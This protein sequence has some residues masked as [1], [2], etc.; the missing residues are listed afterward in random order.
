MS[1]KILIGCYEV[2]GYGG[3]STVAYRLFEDLQAQGFDVSFV[4]LIGQDDAPYLSVMYGDK[5]GNP[6]R[7]ANV[8][9]FFMERA[10]FYPSSAHANLTALIHTLAPDF[11]IGFDFIAA[12]LLKSSA[13]DKRIIFIPTGCDQARHALREGRV[14]N[15]TELLAQIAKRQASSKFH[16]PPHRSG[17]REAQAVVCADLL[18]V[19]SE[20]MR[21]LFQFYFP[22]YAVKLF[23]ET[24][25][26]AEWICQDAA[27]YQPYR[28]PFAER[29]VDVLFVASLWS[30]IE[31][32]W[33]L[34]RALITRH[35]EWK[36][37]V[38]GDTVERVGH[39]TYHGLVADRAALFGLMGNARVVVSPSRL[40]AAPGILWEAAML[41]CNVVASKNCGN[42][43]L[44]HPALLADSLRVEEYSQRIQRALGREYRQHLE[45]FLQ[46][47]SRKMLLEILQVF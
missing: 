4:N 13:P 35:P 46:P 40:D 3:A 29:A 2:P 25:W 18:L 39:A 41:G 12:L 43:E 5:L 27:S 8:H 20:M 21:V 17:P 6:R 23:P 24:L 33:E 45:R 31:K 16:L 11:L 34:G 9:N 15:V 37:H 30:R 22:E 14:Q 36:I 47:S 38:V 28:R 7:L 42:W 10:P 1:R 26:L 44:C 19:H 32:N